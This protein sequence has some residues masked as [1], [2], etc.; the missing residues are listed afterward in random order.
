VHSPHRQTVIHGRIHCFDP[1]GS[2]M[3]LLQVRQHECSRVSG[4]VAPPT[5]SM[6]AAP[7]LRHAPPTGPNRVTFGC[8]FCFANHLERSSLLTHLQVCCP[9]RQARLHEATTYAA[10]HE[11]A[12]L[13]D[14]LSRRSIWIASGGQQFAQCVHQCHGGGETISL[15]TSSSTLPT[16]TVLIT[17][18]LR[19]LI[20]VCFNPHSIGHDR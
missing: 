9:R 2:T 5:S 6:R 10:G 19:I 14:C 17:T 16:V 13:H 20:A 15:Q 7:E 1:T 12:R 8:P 3:A 11:N 18:R 4:S